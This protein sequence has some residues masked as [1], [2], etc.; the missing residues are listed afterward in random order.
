MIFITRGSSLFGLLFILYCGVSFADVREDDPSEAPGEV[1]STYSGSDQTRKPASEAD[2][3][4]EV[5]R[6]EQLARGLEGRLKAYHEHLQTAMLKRGYG[7]Y[8]PLFRTHVNG[9]LLDEID[10]EDADEYK[11]GSF[12]FSLKAAGQALDPDPFSDWV[13]VQNWLD[14]FEATM[15]NARIVLAR[16]D[17]FVANSTE[18]IPREV[19]QQLRKRWRAAAA[20][21]MEAYDHAM[22]I[23]AVS[24]IGGETVPASQ[25]YRFIRGGGRYGVICAFGVCSSQSTTTTDEATRVPVRH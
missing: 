1:A 4:E 13:A 17:L 12:A 16:A 14:G 6:V 24:Y 9:F 15:D 18:N 5:Q 23:R 25:S 11:R 3:R 2:F 19:F 22:A 21:A 7:P 8:H 10:L 20:Q